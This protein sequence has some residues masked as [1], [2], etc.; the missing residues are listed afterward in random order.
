M[1]APLLAIQGL[2]NS[3]GGL[4]AVRDFDLVARAPSSA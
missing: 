3:F 4:Q 2:S 1:T